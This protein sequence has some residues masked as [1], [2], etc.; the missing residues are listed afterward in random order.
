MGVP[1][2]NS[3][4]STSTT[5]PPSSPTLRAASRPAGPPPI[6]TTVSLAISPPCSKFPARRPTDARPGSVVP[7]PRSGVHVLPCQVLLLPRAEPL[8]VPLELGPG[9]LPVDPH[10]L[11][12]RPVV[13]GVPVELADL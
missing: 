10:L 4:F 7:W 12:Q 13:G 8:H 3:S 2:R 9:R 11:E 6:T 1:P 5:R